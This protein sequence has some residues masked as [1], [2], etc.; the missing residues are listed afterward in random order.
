MGAFLKELADRLQLNQVISQHLK[1]IKE[2]I[3]VP[4]LFL[5]QIPFAALPV[6]VSQTSGVIPSSSGVIPPTPR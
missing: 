6:D 5:H 4:H 3:I 1:G 2:L